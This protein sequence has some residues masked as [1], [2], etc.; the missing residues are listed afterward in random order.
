MRH[1]LQEIRAISAG[2]GLPELERLALPEVVQRAVRAHERRTGTHVAVRMEQV[3]ERAPLAVKITVYRLIQEA[4]QNAYLHAGGAGQEVSV[5]SER[6]ELEV[7]VRDAGPG[8]D[9]AQLPPT[10]SHLGLLGMRE[11][12]QSLGGLFKVESVPGQGTCVTAR[13]SLGAQEG[14]YDR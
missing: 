9:T 11:R 7:S 4:L 10:D 3:P 6:G 8:F 14:L 2:L 13:L 12:V 5:T 1:A